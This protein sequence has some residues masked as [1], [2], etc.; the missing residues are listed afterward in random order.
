MRCLD[1]YKEKVINY[2]AVRDRCYFK[3]ACPD[4]VDISVIIPCRSRTYFNKILT[5]CLK[6]AMSHHSEM[7]YSI[8]FV[9]HSDNR[10][11]EEF[12]EGVNY[13]HIPANGTIFNKCMSMNIGALFGCKA[14]YYMFHDLDIMMRSDFFRLLSQNLKS[15]RTRSIQPFRNKRVVYVNDQISMNVRSGKTHINMLIPGSNGIVPGT[16]G[17]PGGSLLV[18]R[19]QFI[20]VGGYDAELFF[21]YSIEDQFFYDK[22][23]L[24]GGVGSCDRP[25][26]EVFHL[27]HPPLW[28]SNSHA[29]EHHAFYES[30][31]RA[32]VEDKKRYMSISNSN[33]RKYFS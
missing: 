8:T 26:I 28:N 18:P 3:L 10:E 25:P 30:F 12:C 17:A 19:D 23:L 7:T 4:D 32:S 6:D 33:F 15:A 22:L 20:E 9:E 13:I 16:P 1:A 5:K 21:G 24:T 31:K 2:E 29:D 11:H 27:Y 14:K